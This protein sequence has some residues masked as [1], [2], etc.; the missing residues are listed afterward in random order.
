M[1]LLCRGVVAV[2][3]VLSSSEAIDLVA[4]FVD[5]DFPAGSSGALPLVGGWVS[6]VPVVDIRGLWMG[7]LDWYLDACVDLPV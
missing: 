5:G 3:F 6:S 1:D 4:S 7:L 2:G